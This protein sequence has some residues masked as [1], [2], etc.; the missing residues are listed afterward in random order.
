[1]GPVVGL[2]VVPFGLGTTRTAFA[3]DLDFRLNNSGVLILGDSVSGFEPNNPRFRDFTTQLAFVMSPRMASP[4]ETLG[5]SGFHI[6]AM[7]SGSFVSADEPYWLV[8]ERGRRT[9]NTPDLLQTLQLDIRKGLPLSFEVGVNVMWLADSELFAPGLEVRWA[10]QEG[11]AYIPDVSVRGAVNHLVGNRDLSLTTVGAE[12]MVSKSFGVGGMVNLAPYAGW[13]VIF[14]D[15][16]SA[17]IDP[18][19]TD[20]DDSLNNLVFDDINAR[21]NINH[22]ITTGLRILYHVV[23]ISVQ[24]EFQVLSDYE[25][26]GRGVISITTKLGL[27]Y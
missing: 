20:T 18:T 10:L 27:D 2:A 21:D 16:S 26:G 17:V 5:H 1:M 6:S 11:Y 13:S 12:L 3:G 14:I 8:T 15:A 23:N 24:G 4:A 22:R 9:G 25:T 7:W 19:P